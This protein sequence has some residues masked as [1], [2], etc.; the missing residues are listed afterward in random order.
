MLLAGAA[1]PAA[2][3]AVKT[4]PAKTAPATKTTPT[5]TVPGT[6][7]TTTTTSKISIKWRKPIRIERSN[8]GGLNS[9]ACPSVKLCVAVDQSGR[10]LSSTA[11]MGTGNWHLASG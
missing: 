9:I 7:G 2:A 11:P 5:T 8:F 10:V 1:L 4:P 6:T 3:L